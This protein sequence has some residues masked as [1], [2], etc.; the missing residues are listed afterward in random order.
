MSENTIIRLLGVD[1]D[2]VTRALRAY[3][4]GQQ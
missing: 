1:D 4:K 2:Y 3:L